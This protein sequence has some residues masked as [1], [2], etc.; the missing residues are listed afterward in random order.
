MPFEKGWLSIAEIAQLMD[1]SRQAAWGY[2]KRK[3]FKNAYKLPGGLTSEWR[4][5]V[6]DVLPYIPKDKLPSIARKRSATK[7]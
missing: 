1:V 7:P 5:P 2:V 3:I 4:V 6:D